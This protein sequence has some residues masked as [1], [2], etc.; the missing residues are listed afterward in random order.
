MTTA[1]IIVTW[2]LLGLVSIRLIGGLAIEGGNILPIVILVIW[3]ILMPIFG[4]AWSLVQVN[5]FLQY[6][7]AR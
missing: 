5:K 4:I 1:Y 3:P 2:I 6:Y 7:V